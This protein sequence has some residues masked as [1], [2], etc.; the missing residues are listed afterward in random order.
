MIQGKLKNGLVLKSLKGATYTVV[1]LLGSGG[2]GEVYEVNSSEGR[3]ALKWYFKATST[4]EQKNNIYNLVQTAAPSNN[5]L[6]P[7][8]FISADDGTF[9]YIMK[10]RPSN[11]KGIPDLLNNLIDVDF[12]NLVLAV[13]NLAKEYN[14]L[15][16]KGFSYKDISD[17][18]VFFDP[19]TGNVLICD[20][21][22]ASINGL[23][24]SG[25]YGTMRFMA[26]EIVRGEAVPSRN[27]DLYSLAVLIFNMLFIS[28]PLEGKNEYNIHALDENACKRLYG[29][30]PIF[31]FDPND[32]T[33]APVPGWH[34]NA[35]IYWNIYPQFLKDV[36][37]KAFTEGINIPSKR[38]VERTWM[39]VASKLYDSIIE[40]P[41]CGAQIF[42]DPDKNERECWGCKRKVLCPPKLK[43]G[44]KT[45]IIK[46]DTII[47]S[48]H[49]NNDFDLDTKVGTVTQN[50]KNPALWG[51]KNETNDVWTYIKSDGTQIQVAPGRNAALVAGSKINF[52]KVIAEI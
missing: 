32:K 33:N 9:G 41:N 44:N 2:Q 20:N 47:R 28:H 48:H 36:F 30:N 10:L 7:E 25:V 21:D 19:K 45:I 17:K 29:K 12:K 18:N 5:F 27:T 1:K 37:I 3:K 8:D 38:I 46:L 4:S 52:G 14:L 50:P 49:I 43:I 11:Y 34:D 42:V 16:Q 15:H 6:W 51:L 13:F 26:P 39:D 23:A 35:I 22:N 24:D 31:I 40:C